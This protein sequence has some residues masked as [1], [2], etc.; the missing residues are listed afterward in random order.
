MRGS[1]LAHSRAA[2]LIL[3]LALPVA[4]CSGGDS[5]EPSLNGTVS[6]QVS[7]SGTAVSGATLTLSQGTTSR[8]ATSSTAGAYSFSAVPAGSWTLGLTVPEGFELAS[9]QTA[10]VP[11][12]V[13]GGQTTTVDFAL[14]TPTGGPVVDIEL[15]GMTFDPATV[16]IEVGTTVQ[17]INVSGGPH[18]VTPDGHAAW[19]AASLTTPGQT[20]SHTFTTAGTFAYYCDPH[21]SVGMTGV[22]TVQ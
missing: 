11:V 16:T 9:G 22:I 12:T 3:A 15:V 7:A 20:F 4:S 6:G 5:T 19:T 8:T 13:T 21:R 1:P 10:S 14:T 18:T 17:W 2:L